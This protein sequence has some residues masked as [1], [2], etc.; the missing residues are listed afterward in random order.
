MVW[1][2]VPHRCPRFCFVRRFLRPH[3]H[4]APHVCVPLSLS[5]IFPHPYFLSSHFPLG[6]L[7]PND[8]FPFT[9]LSLF[10]HGFPVTR[11]LGSFFASRVSCAVSYFF[12]ASRTAFLLLF[13]F[14][15]GWG[16]LHPHLPHVGDDPGS[17]GS[18]RQFLFRLVFPSKTSAQQARGRSTFSQCFDESTFLGSLRNCLSRSAKSSS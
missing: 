17:R 15:M 16:S 13:S 10:R 14:P 7:C 1:G 18:A 5:V 2:R 12:V 11:P 6:F 8:R 3:S 4:P 9:P